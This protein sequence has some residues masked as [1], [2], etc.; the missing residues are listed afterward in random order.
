MSMSLMNVSMYVEY[1]CLVP[2]EVRKGHQISW[3][4]S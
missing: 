1:A 3:T 4:W 2:A